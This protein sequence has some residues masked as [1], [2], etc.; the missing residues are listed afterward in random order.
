MEGGMTKIQAPKIGMFEC[1]AG[2]LGFA[3]A[4]NTAFAI[5]AIQKCYA[6][7]RHVGPEDLVDALQESIEREYRRAIFDHPSH[8]VDPNLAYSLLISFWSRS[9]GRV[10]LFRTQD[11]ILHSCYGSECIGIGFEL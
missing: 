2:K 7:I 11:H 4:G 6:H 5:S 3:F 10:A 9:Q 8:A 1:A